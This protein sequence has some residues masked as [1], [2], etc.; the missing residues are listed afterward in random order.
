M[1][2]RRNFDNTIFGCGEIYYSNSIIIIIDFVQTLIPNRWFE[3]VFSTYF[4]IEIS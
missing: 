4:S 2:E 1:W 3:K